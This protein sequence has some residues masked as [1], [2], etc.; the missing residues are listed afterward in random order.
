MPSRLSLPVMGCP[1]AHPTGVPLASGNPSN[2]STV[3]WGLSGSRPLEAAA[4]GLVLVAGRGYW[5]V[6]AGGEGVGG[7]VGQGS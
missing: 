7:P 4:P 1:T 5:R 2:S 3:R 6:L